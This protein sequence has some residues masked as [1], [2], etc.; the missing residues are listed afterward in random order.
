MPRPSAINDKTRDKVVELYQEGW[1]GKDISAETGVSQPMVYEILVKRG[2]RPNR[3][4][5][6]SEELTVDQVLERALA[7][8]REAQRWKDQY[9]HEHV[10]N[11]RLM[12]ELLKLRGEAQAS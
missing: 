7:A 10:L 8:E 11:E 4:R 5:R 6:R 12:D 1:K 3:Q 2:V 9:E